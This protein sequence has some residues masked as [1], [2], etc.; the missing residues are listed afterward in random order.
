MP[1]DR[2][3]VLGTGAV[4]RLQ[5]PIGRPGHGNKPGSKILYRLMVETVD[6]KTLF[7]EDPM[8]QCPGHDRYFMH[9]LIPGCTNRLLMVYTGS[10]YLIVNIAEKVSSR[11]NIHNL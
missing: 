9:L 8:Q 7:P 4:E 5:K 3:E 6:P 10:G 2:P 1:L 11:S